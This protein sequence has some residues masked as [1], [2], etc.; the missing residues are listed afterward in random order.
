[1]RKNRLFAWVLAVAMMISMLPTTAFA[2]DGEDH[3]E[4]VSQPTEE[5]ATEAPTEAETE[6]PTEAATEPPAEEVTESEDPVAAVQAQ[7]DDL[8]MVSMLETMDDDALDALYET[9]QA[10][11]DAYNALSAEQQA[12][13]VDLEQLVAI[14]EWFNAQ[15]APLDDCTY[16]ERGFCTAHND[17]YQPATQDESG[18]YQIGNAGQLFWFAQQVN[19]GQTSINGKLTADI[20]L[21]NKSWTPIG[22]MSQSYIGTFDGGGHTIS[23][24]NV[25]VEADSGNVYAGLFGYIGENNGGTTTVQNVMVS[26]SVSA[27]TNSGNANAGGVVGFAQ[28]STIRNCY[29]D[30]T[31]KASAKKS[32]DAEAYAGGIVGNQ[33]YGKVELC[34]N[35][36]EVIAE[37]NATGRFKQAT[38]YAGGISGYNNGTTIA[39]VNVQNC[40]NTGAVSA[41]DNS[42]RGRHYVGGIVGSNNASLTACYSCA[43]NIRGSGGSSNVGAVAGYTNKVSN[44]YYLKSNG[45]GDSVADGKDAAAFR[46]GEVTYKLNDGNTEDPVWRQTCG[47]GYPDLSGTGAIVYLTAPCPS[48]TN[49]SE[50]TKAHMF[51]DH[52]C[53]YCG[54]EQHHHCIYGDKNCTNAAHDEEIVFEEWTSGNSLPDTA[55]NYCLTTDVTVN[56]EWS[57]ASGTVLCLNGHTITSEISNG[58]SAIVLERG[59]TFTLTDCGNAGKI[60]TNLN[61]DQANNAHA[62]RV[63]EGATFNFYGGTI[64][65]WFIKGMG[66]QEH[67]KYGGGVYNEGTFNMYGGSITGCMAFISGGAVYNSGSFTMYDG[68]ITGNAAGYEYNPSDAE[69]KATRYGG[70]VHNTASG[71]I[72]LYGGTIT[73]NKINAMWYKGVFYGETTVRNVYLDGDAKI[74]VGANFSGTVGVTVQ[75]DKEDFDYQAFILSEG[76]DATGLTYDKKNY[77]IDEEGKLTCSHMNEKGTFNFDTTTH[78]CNVCGAACTHSTVDDNGKCTACSLQHIASVKNGDETTYYTDLKD[79]FEAVTTGG[80]ITLLVDVDE[81]NWSPTEAVLYEINNPATYTLD[82][83]G[84]TIGLNSCFIILKAGNLTIKGSGEITGTLKEQDAGNLKVEGGTYYN[85]NSNRTGGIGALLAEGYGYCQTSDSG[86]TW[87]DSTCTASSVTNCTVAKLPVQTITV[88]VTG[89][90]VTQGSDGVH[91]FPYGTD[92]SLAFDITLAEAGDYTYQITDGSDSLSDTGDY[93]GQNTSKQTRSLKECAAGEHA[94]KIEVTKDGYTKSCEVKVKIEKAT[95]TEGTDYTAPKAVEGLTYD[96]DLKELITAGELKI[97]DL[98]DCSIQYRLGEDGEWTDVAESCSAT[99]AGKYTVY[100][101]IKGDQNY[102]GVGSEEH[103]AGEIDVTVKK[104]T[105]TSADYDAP[106]GM[107]SLT[108]NGVAQTLIV[109]GN[110]SIAT[111]WYKLGDGAWSKDLPSAKNVGKYTVSWYIEGGTNYE[112]VGAQEDPAGT[113]ETTIKPKPIEAHIEFN[114]KTYD[115]TTNA[116]VDVEFNGVVSGETLEQGKDYTVTAAFDSKN[117]GER[118]VTATVTLKN[119]NYTFENGTT[120]NIQGTESIIPKQITA[121][122]CVEDKIYDGTTDATVTATVNVNDLI[123]GDSITITG[124]TGMF[125]DADVGTDKTVTIN[126]TNATKTGE[127]A[128]NYDVII[129]TTAE[130]SITPKKIENAVITLSDK[131]LDYTGKLHS[132]TVQSVTLDGVTLTAGEDYTISGDLSATNANTYTVTIEGI[133]NYTSTAKQTWTINKAT[134]EVKQA[135]ATVTFGDELSASVIRATCDVVGSFRWDSSVTGYGDVGTRTLSATFVPTDMDNYNT[136]FGV[137]VVVTVNKAA[138]PTLTDEKLTIKWSDSGE[139][140]LDIAAGMPGDAGDMTYAVGTVSGDVADAIV[141]AEVKDG[142]LT[143]RLDADEAYVGKTATIP[144]TIG[145]KNYESATRNVTVLVEN[146]EVPQIE[147]KQESFKKVYDGKSMELPKENPTVNGK[148]IPGQWHWEKY[149]PNTHSSVAPLALESGSAASQPV[150]VADTMQWVLV[151]EPEDQ[152]NYAPI[153]KIVAVVITKRSVKISSEDVTGEYSG[154]ALTNGSNGAQVQGGVDGENFT[155]TFTGSQTDIGSG[156]NTFTVTD[157]TADLDNYDITVEPGTLRVAVP[158]DTGAA[159]KDLKKETAT[160][161]DSAVVK[162]TL[163]LVNKY[164]AMEPTA[165]EKQTLQALKNELEAVS[166]QLEKAE[167]AKAD[168]AI[169][170]VDKIDSS[171]AKSGDKTKLTEAKNAIEKALKDFGGNYSEAEKKEL[172]DK[173]E[174]IEAA[175]GA[176]KKAEQTDQSAVRTGDLANLELWLVTFVVALCGLAAIAVTQRKKKEQK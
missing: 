158:S 78:Q 18:V 60:T 171:N 156:A 16:D 6:A 17:C 150:G 32:A 124:L 94:I 65:G 39:S 143:F 92:V 130:A 139:K 118:A 102:A 86:K 104:A 115:G 113:I 129:S 79:A 74:T 111:F 49:D 29:S 25:V 12:Q 59:T 9:A 45:L 10:V 7:I 167:A 107:E 3:A 77:A 71:K 26:G 83:N 40:Y 23:D 53:G 175:L 141:D 126:S 69:E 95:L 133:G 106:T 166:G 72:I 54:K 11:S 61:K 62:V 28:H 67:A 30:C 174:R 114:D 50:E 128:D 155:I 64:T 103:P 91:T 35:T 70:G 19:G 20:S 132:V 85:I 122:V 142:K 160:S 33:W 110:T 37:A 168:E 176:I 98:N 13:V 5:V 149:D 172:N 131:E 52:V 137:S 100:W 81:N 90:N 38:A 41:T 173:L 125:D 44:C 144:V 117:V 51:V 14:L 88:S 165:E 101:Y 27:T 55:G 154:N 48:Y 8:P 147:L 68:S 169:T 21:K 75:A 153:E 4:V 82:L 123:E 140:T 157:G 34:V 56:S 66:D 73:G 170:N 36:G 164:L 47:E 135:Q 116:T 145:S 109:A 138:A 76:A 163:E 89:A 87:K 108:Y 42:G 24:L 58:R 63:A 112:N 46:S 84:K 2:V 1:M 162:Q 57:P 31:V 151:F 134:P 99:V 161:A 97:G 127:G 105:L 159:V 121:T 146:R 15:V 120:Y 93:D 80:T 43:D 136:V 96:G 119:G 148:P 152:V 22:S